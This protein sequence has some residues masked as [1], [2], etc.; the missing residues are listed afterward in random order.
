MAPKANGKHEGDELSDLF[1][2][3]AKVL[4]KSPEPAP[5]LDWI[6]EAGPAL[7]PGIARGIDPRTG[8]VGLAFRAMGVAIYNA[9]PLPEAGYRSRR[10]PEP[11]R[12]EPCQCGSGRKYKNCCLRLRGILDLTG[13]NTLRYVL[14]SLPKKRFAELPESRVDPL[15]VWDTGRQWHEEGDD[16]SAAALLE[17][18]FAGDGLLAGRLGPL[19]DQLMD[20]YLALG[21]ERKRER[22]V[23]AAHARGDREL[24]AVALERRS[25]MLADRGDIDAAWASFREAQR[26]RPEDPALAGLELT[27]LMSRG[28]AERA[29]ERARFWLARLERRNDPELAQLAGFLRRVHADPHAAMAEIDCERFPALGHLAALLAAAPSPQARYAVESRGEAGGVLVARTEIADVESRWRKVFPQQKPILTATQLDDAGMWNDPRPWLDFLEREPQAWQSFDVLDDLAMAVEALPAL[30]ADAKILEPLLERGV[31]LLQANLAGAGAPAPTLR[32]G[33]TAN[34]P[35]LR[36]L[37]HYAYR[38]AAAMDRGGSPGRFVALAERLLAL[39]P[40]DNHF[41]REPLSRAYLQCG[42]PEKV[43]ALCARFPGDSCGPVLN[44]LLALLRLGRRG[45]ALLALRDAARPHRTAIKIL[46]AEAPKPPKP[47]GVLGITVGGR[48]EA[49]RYRSAH[50]ELWERDGALDWLRAAWAE[51]RK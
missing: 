10:I 38:E 39:N 48:N 9:M 35:A 50:R 14:D 5:F 19:F 26:E 36:M 32:W 46:L 1:E 28:E 42:E 41:V 33:W 8:P 3:A 27:L 21:N 18:W 12:N 23:A 11:G 44:H 6:F 4:L 51:V 20:C 15:A 31:A 24:R 45:D 22:L 34:R 25:T 49:W 37:A 43:I 2:A 17:P 29:R 16:E 47:D 13:F 30:G 40:D 7:A